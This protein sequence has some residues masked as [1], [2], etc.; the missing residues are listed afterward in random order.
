MNMGSQI[1]DD[2][3][4]NVSVFQTHVHSRAA[5][6]SCRDSSG[7]L[8]VASG[9]DWETQSKSGQVLL[10]LQRPCGV[11]ADRAIGRDEACDHRDGHENH[12][13]GNKRQR[14]ARF[15]TYQ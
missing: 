12:Q 5:K 2:S 4:I 10:R 15:H 14:V 11:D 13:H 3:H 1:L 9:D 6:W 8:E 7:Y